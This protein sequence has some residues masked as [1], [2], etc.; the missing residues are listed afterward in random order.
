MAVNI[1]LAIAVTHTACD[2]RFEELK[3]KTDWLPAF[4]KQLRFGRN[5]SRYSCGLSQLKQCPSL[6]GSSI[7]A[8]P[9]SNPGSSSPTPGS[10]SSGC[11]GSES[12]RDSSAS[13]L[14]NSAIA[15]IQL[16]RRASWPNQ[17]CRPLLTHKGV[18]WAG[19]R[20]EKNGGKRRLVKLKW[21][22]KCQL[23]FQ[24]LLKQHTTINK[25]CC[26]T[27][28]LYAIVLIYDREPS[29]FT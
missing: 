7:A 16:Y 23:Q 24:P 12:S 14:P 5:V 25:D 1:D 11:P 26:F 18:E 4:T 19:R 22:I 8:S 10:S 27:R 21:G 17:R 20:K 29:L 2:P 28:Y 3:K 9:S 13:P 6:T 15:L